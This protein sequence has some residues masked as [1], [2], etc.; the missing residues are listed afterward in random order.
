MPPRFLSGL[1][2]TASTIML[3]CVEPRVIW[4]RVRACAASGRTSVAPPMS[5]M[6]SRRLIRS[7]PLQLRKCCKTISSLRT[8]HQFAA[9]QLRGIGDKPFRVTL[10]LG[11]PLIKAVFCS[12]APAITDVPAAGRH[13]RECVPIGDIHFACHKPAA[14]KRCLTIQLHLE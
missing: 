6:N 2:R 3:T 11:A 13:N 8:S 12:P 4:R 9:P 7:P 5:P 1:A 14:G 10:R